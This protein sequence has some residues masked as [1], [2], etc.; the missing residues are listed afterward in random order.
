[1][2]NGNSW[3]NTESRNLNVVKEKSVAEFRNIHRVFYNAPDYRS[4]EAAARGLEA[5]ALGGFRFLSKYNL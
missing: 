3:E 4:Y 2:K 1:M 5:V